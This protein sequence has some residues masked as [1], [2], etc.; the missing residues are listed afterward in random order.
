MTDIPTVAFYEQNLS[1]GQNCSYY[2]NSL[3]LMVTIQQD[4]IILYKTRWDL[5]FFLTLL[6]QHEDRHHLK[7]S[8]NKLT[9]ERYIEDKPLVYN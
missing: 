1:Y 4:I 9:I 6:W 8:S 7:R 2:L 5:V 3:S